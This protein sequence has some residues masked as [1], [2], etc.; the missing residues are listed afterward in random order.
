MQAA[1]SYPTTPTFA[2]GTNIGK[3]HGLSWGTFFIVLH[4]PCYICEN[5]LD[6]AQ[7][8]DIL[9]PFTCMRQEN[10]SCS[11]T[12]C[13]DLHTIPPEV[14]VTWIYKQQWY[15]YNISFRLLL[16]RSRILHKSVKFHY[17]QSVTLSF[18]DEP[19]EHSSSMHPL[20]MAVSSSACRL[21]T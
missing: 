18:T 15:H 14:P 10:C 3:G 2:E 4:S 5:I 21:A 6:V 7:G 1:K 12:A 16:C 8:D 11:V 20:I 19:L 9:F 13:F 17:I